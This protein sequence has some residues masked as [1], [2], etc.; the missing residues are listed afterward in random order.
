[1][2]P[3]AQDVAADGHPRVWDFHEVLMTFVLLYALILAFAAWSLV[4]SVRVAVKV[5]RSAT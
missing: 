1:L 3:L 2:A 5:H 4:L